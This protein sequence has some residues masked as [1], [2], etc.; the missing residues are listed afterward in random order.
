MLSLGW[1]TFIAAR[2]DNTTGNKNT[3][4]F[5]EARL[6]KKVFE[7]RFQTLTANPD[8]VL[9]AADPSKKLMVF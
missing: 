2:A 3:V 1:K 6:P 8:M 9:F 5:T 4:V 7:Q